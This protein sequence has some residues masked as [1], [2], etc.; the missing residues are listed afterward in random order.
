MI[1]MAEEKKYS[2]EKIFLYVAL[3]A[4]IFASAAF[5]WYA[6][7]ESAGSNN[8]QNVTIA[9]AKEMIANDRYLVILDVRTPTEFS[10]G[11]IEGA[12]NIPVDTIQVR[13]KELNPRDKILI[14][15]DSGSRSVFA[16]EILVDKGF[17]RIYNM[18]EGY[19]AWKDAGYP[20]FCPVCGG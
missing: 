10:N 12:I 20:V 4:F 1:L 2:R 3:M 13:I 11:H 5:V 6:E 16:S 15:C 9:Q 19:E 8:F 14:Y 18:F 17:T 7:A